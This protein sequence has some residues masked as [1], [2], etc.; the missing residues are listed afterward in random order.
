M[1]IVIAIALASACICIA[2]EDTI[3]AKNVELAEK[4]RRMED[5]MA[6]T[7]YT[8]DTAA[9]ELK[10]AKRKLESATGE[11]TS[12]VGEFQQLK[13]AHAEGRHEQGEAEGADPDHEGQAGGDDGKG[14]RCS[15]GSSVVAASRPGHR[16]RSAPW[17]DG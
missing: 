13:A 9:E 7:E 17:H 15:H 12:Q 6:N 5:E 16:R 2:A 8:R 14:D 11:L 3:Q 10:A 4:I 1:R